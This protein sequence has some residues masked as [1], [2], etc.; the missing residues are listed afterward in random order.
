MG[1]ESIISGRGCST[2]STASTAI[3][4]AR[5]GVTSRDLPACVLPYDFTQQAA[6]KEGP[7][8]GA[9]DRRSGRAAL[10]LCLAHPATDLQTRAW[11]RETRAQSRVWRRL[12]GCRSPTRPMSLAAWWGFA[13][14]SATQS[15]TLPRPPAGASVNHRVCVS[16]VLRRTPDMTDHLAFTSLSL[17]V[18]QLRCRPHSCV[19]GLSQV[20]ACVACPFVSLLPVFRYHCD[21]PRLPR[22]EGD[23]GYTPRQQPKTRVAKLQRFPYLYALG[24]PCSIATSC[25]PPRTAN[26]PERTVAPNLYAKT[27]RLALLYSIRA[28]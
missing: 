19:V 4:I 14:V 23:Q 3:S 9:S 8:Y 27:W 28:P 26:H 10:F 11:R 2:N 17:H 1:R 21:R 15:R 25:R 13:V 24:H 20:L 22:L 18:Y 16:M 7:A 6:C 12:S 5:R